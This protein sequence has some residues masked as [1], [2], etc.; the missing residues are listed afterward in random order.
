MSME[1]RLIQL[2]Q[3]E[4]TTLKLHIFLNHVFITAL[5]IAVVLL[6]SCGG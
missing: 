1:Y 4:V 3:K 2:L 5:A 6:H